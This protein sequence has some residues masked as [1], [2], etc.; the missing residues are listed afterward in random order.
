MLILGRNSLK[1]ISGLQRSQLQ[2]IDVC[3]VSQTPHNCV[4]ASWIPSAAVVVW[5]WGGVEVEHDTLVCRRNQVLLTMCVCLCWTGYVEGG[6][7]GEAETSIQPLSAHCGSVTSGCHE[8]A[9]EFQGFA[10]L[11]KWTQEEAVW[12]RSGSLKGLRSLQFQSAGLDICPGF[13]WTTWPIF[14]VLAICRNIKST[15]Q[16]HGN[17]QC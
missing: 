4:T 9:G 10:H 13:S 1:K 7:M 11:L 15:V 16:P 3:V 5:S 2:E 12:S 17:I 14:C 6:W 8:T